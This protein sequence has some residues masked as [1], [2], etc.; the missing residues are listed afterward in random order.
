MIQIIAS[1]I[2]L[3]FIGL[4]KQ[5]MR[6]DRLISWLMFFA[7][8][9]L[10]M[11]F[12][13][14][15]VNLNKETF[16][17]LWSTSKI[18]DI[19]I[20]FSPGLGEHRLLLPLFFLSLVTILHNNIFRYEEKKSAFNAFILLNFASLSLLTCSENYVQMTTAVFVTDILGYLILKDVDSSHRYVIYNFFAD[21]CLFMV[22]AL[23][24]GKLQSLSLSD[25]P[26]YEQIGRHKDFVG[27]MFLIAVFIKMGLFMFQSYLLDLSAARLQ[28]MSAVNLLFAPLTGIL[29]LL[30]LHG[31][32]EISDLALPLLKIISLLTMIFGLLNFIM[33]DNL[34]KKL[35]YLNMGFLGLLLLMLEN[36][37][38]RWNWQ[39]SFY[40]SVGYFINLLFLKMYLYQNH[41]AKVSEML[42]GRGTNSFILRTTLVQFVLIANIFISL[43]YR[44][45]V[46]HEQYW[47]LASG[48]I[49]ICAIATVLNHIYH[50]P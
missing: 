30:K 41:E 28:R 4:V 29:V 34:K 45:S 39:Y 15:A 27:L 44:I 17:F 32:V 10:F 47:I 23:V 43:I 12:A 3:S 20:D 25:L 11:E 46:K 48:I 36:H 40:Y 9:I 5:R 1:I 50:T 38:L 8:T 21:T 24:C 19:T 6:Y 13:T 31:L 14:N 37:N 42:N 16:S 33:I 7:A 49:L 26:R 22:L 2:V 35:V 18:G